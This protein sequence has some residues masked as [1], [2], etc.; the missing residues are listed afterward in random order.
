MFGNRKQYA[1]DPGLLSPRE[2]IARAIQ[3]FREQLWNANLDCL[4]H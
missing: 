2:A 1:T 4:D 3:R